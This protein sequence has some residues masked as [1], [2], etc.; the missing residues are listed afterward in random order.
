VILRGT[1]DKIGDEILRLRK[2][3]GVEYLMR[4][5]LSH[6][7]FMPLTDKVLPRII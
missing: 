5:P 3:I 6:K 1:P 4:A 7:S 2:E